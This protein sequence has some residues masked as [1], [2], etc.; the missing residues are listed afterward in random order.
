MVPFDLGHSGPPQCA[1]NMVP[2]GSGPP[3]CASSMTSVCHICKDTDHLHV[4]LTRSVTVG[5]ISGKTQHLKNNNESTRFIMI[6]PPQG[7][8][9]IGK[10][11][12]QCGIS[13]SDILSDCTVTMV[14]P[15]LL[16][17]LSSLGSDKPQKTNPHSHNL[18]IVNVINSLQISHNTGTSSLRFMAPPS[19]AVSVASSQGGASAA[20][21]AA[22]SA[23]SSSV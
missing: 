14:T 19:L 22:A 7:I 16:D 2:F 18:I 1:S 15:W 6:V 12:S 21:P 10:Y 17:H 9:K 20:S 3:Q 8:N 11:M 4:R 13:I 5:T 23:W